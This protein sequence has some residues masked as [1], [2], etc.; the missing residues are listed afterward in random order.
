MQF[1]FFREYNLILRGREKTRNVHEKVIFSFL[2][3]FLCFRFWVPLCYLL[4]LKLVIF[5]LIL[6]NHNATIIKNILASRGFSLT[7]IFS[8]EKNI[9]TILFCFCFVSILLLTDYKVKVRNFYRITTYMSRC[10]LE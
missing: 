7:C 2:P 5:C 1:L 6:R 10:F 4:I 3:C 9:D 8:Q